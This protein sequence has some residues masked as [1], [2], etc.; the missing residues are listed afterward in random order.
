LPTVPTPGIH[1]CFPT[2]REGAFAPLRSTPSLSA[3]YRPPQP[4]LSTSRYPETPVASLL[5]LSIALRWCSSP[6]CWVCR[7]PLSHP[8]WVSAPRAPLRHRAPRF[9]FGF[10]PTFKVTLSRGV[11]FGLSAPELDL[12]LS[13]CPLV[14]SRLAS[15]RLALV[16]KLP[17]ILS[18]RFP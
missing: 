5:R 13:S 7:L 8:G 6:I 12:G 3:F 18:D 16:C 10:C 14:D 17:L 2:R 11:D 9:H 15:R 1:I 4:S